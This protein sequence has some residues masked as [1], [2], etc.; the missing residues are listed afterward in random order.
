MGRRGPIAAAVANP[1]GTVTPLRGDVAAPL[2]LPRSR[3][4]PPTWLG[5]EAAA[6]WRRVVPELDRRG[7][8]NKV[9]RAT[10]TMWC[11][12]W[13]RWVELDRQ[14]EREGATVTGYRGATV[15]NPAWQLWRESAALLVSLAR[16]L[17]TSP[18]GRMRMAAPDESD[19]DAAGDVLD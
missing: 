9:D 4:N 14:L 1:G 16:E 7:I 18:N 13:A 11:R 12:A 2:T 17:G 10:L 15:K 8:L 3:P 19:D 5:R 6:E